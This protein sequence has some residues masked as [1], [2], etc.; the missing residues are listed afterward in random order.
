VLV[1]RHKHGTYFVADVKREQLSSGK[2]NKLIQRTALEDDEE[3]GNVTTWLEQEPGS[4]GK[5]SAEISVKQLAG[6]TVRIERVTGD[7]IARAMPS[8]AQVEAGNVYLLEAEWN[9][10]FVDELHAF[11][12]GRLKDQA[13]GFSGAMNKLMRRRRV[14]PDDYEAHTE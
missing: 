1:G 7:K 12:Q 9:K 14:D 11:P 2:R 6:F 13:D 4:G 3:Y 10:P 8:S 5:E